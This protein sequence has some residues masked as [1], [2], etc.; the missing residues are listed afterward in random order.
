MNED[1]ILNDLDER[2]RPAAA[3][4]KARAAGR[5]VPAFDPERAPTVPLAPA[6]GRTPAMR[7]PLFGAAAAVAVVALLAGGLWISTRDSGEETPADQV[8]SGSIQPYLPTDVPDGMELAAAFESGPEELDG[9]FADDV[10]SLTTFGPAVDDPRVALFASSELTF[11][12]DF[13]SGST[14]SGSSDSGSGLATCTAQLEAGSEIESCEAT[15]DGAAGD[16][17]DDRDDIDVEEVEVGDRTGYVRRDGVIPGVLL[18]VPVNGDG[19]P[20]VNVFGPDVDLDVLIAIAAATTVE[21]LDVTVGPEG[22]PSGWH[23]L[24]TDPEGL[25]LISPMAAFLGATGARSTAAYYVDGA[26]EKTMIVNS[27]E[28]PASSLHSQRLFLESADTVQVRGH[29][30]IVGRFPTGSSNAGEGVTMSWPEGWV[31]RWTERPG[32]M[33]SLSGLG[34]TREELL[35][36]AETLQPVDATRWRELLEATALGDLHPM[37]HDGR[38][39]VELGRGRFADGTAW[40]LRYFAGGTDE[41]GGYEESVDLEVAVGGGSNTSHSYSAVGTAIDGEGNLVE[42]PAPVFRSSSGLEKAGRTFAYGL[43]RDDVDRIEV[44]SADGAA[45]GEVEVVRAE[46]Q[47]AWVFEATPDAATLV[48][49]AADGTEL[50]TDRVPTFG[51]GSLD[52]P[53]DATSIPAAGPTT[54]AGG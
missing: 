37:F 11:G 33:L 19:G 49:F 5:S 14:D 10:G 17:R 12:S 9:S 24:D 53:G 20:V 38:P 30:A 47:V 18:E 32:E 22:L 26:A 29:E 23:S 8:V 43:V 44:R 48:A 27:S 39:S 52:H 16:D 46:G 42:T 50:G 40:V 36:A 35:A 28:R 51:D 13:D 31:V 4:L 3:D 54:T 6:T 45:I 7:R 15:S 25:A 2:A 21:G 34:L 1:Q 41:G